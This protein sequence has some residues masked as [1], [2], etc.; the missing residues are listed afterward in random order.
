M[1]NHAGIYLGTGIIV[2]DGH[3]SQGKESIQYP[4]GAGRTLDAGQD[5]Q[6][7]IPEGLKKLILQLDQSL[8]RSQDLALQFLEATGNKALSVGQ[9]L[10]A[11]IIGR[12]L[13]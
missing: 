7:F 1:D 12:Y 3:R 11:L 8:F 6:H 10:L 4:Q 5:L 9:G 13:G 2:I